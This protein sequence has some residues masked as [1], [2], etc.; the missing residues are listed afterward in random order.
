L[1]QSS[2]WTNCVELWPI[3]FQMETFVPDMPNALR[4]TAGTLNVASF[5]A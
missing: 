3:P 2:F 1:T 4:V 5:A